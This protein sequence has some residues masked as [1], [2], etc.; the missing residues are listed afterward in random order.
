VFGRR[1]ALSAVDQAPLPNDLGDPPLGEAAGAP[2][3][4]IRDLLWTHAGLLRDPSGLREL[5]GSSDSLAKLIAA[6]AM[7]RQES[8]GCHLRADF[9]NADAGLD[10]RH[11]VA[12]SSGEWLEQWK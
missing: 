9:P 1:A 3:D 12:S 10:R 11:L 5:S 7:S 4:E 2:S 8:R 6:G